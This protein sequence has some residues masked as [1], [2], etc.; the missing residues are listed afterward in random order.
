[1]MLG[2]A[3]SD[4]L[5]RVSPSDPVVLASVTTLVLA[6]AAVASVIPAW[7]ATGREAREILQGD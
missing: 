7:L 2:G 6:V 5:Y 3:A 4:L 1:M